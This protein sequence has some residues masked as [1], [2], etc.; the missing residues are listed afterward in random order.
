L[1]RC[2]ETDR[3]P[4]GVVSCE[5]GD[6]AGGW[7]ADGGVVAVMVVEVQPAVKCPGALHHQGNMS[8]IE[9]ARLTGRNSTSNPAEMPT[10]HHGDVVLFFEV[11]GSATDP[12]LLLI[13][14]LGSQCINYDEQW[15]EKFAA[16]GYRVIRFD[17]R[18]VGLSSKL[19]EAAYGLRDMAGDAV[20]VLGAAKVERA[21]VMGVSMGGMIAQWIAIDHADRLLSLTSVMSSTSEPEY[22]QSSPEALAGL[23]AEP[24]RTRDEFVDREVAER[25]I[26]GSKPE[27]IDAPY[28][29]ARAARAFDRCHYPDGISR[30]MQA[31]MRDRDR[32]N[33]LRSLTV[34]TLVMHGDR[35]TL[36]DPSGG[37]RTAELIP[38]ARYVEIEGMGHDYPA[39]VWDRWVETWADFVRSAVKR[40]GPERR[41]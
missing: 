33:G 27:W 22:G 9:Q 34:P 20:A 12:T 2:D 1:F 38:D 26:Y 8:A 10:A 36:V 7:S 16:R 30:Q 32:V 17:N 21:H 14:G 13:N 6:A 18:D 19:D 37:R 28:L 11:F 15:C 39:A 5:V 4:L 31:I 3:P 40:P 29:R 35:D 41:P 25:R 24:A 23:L